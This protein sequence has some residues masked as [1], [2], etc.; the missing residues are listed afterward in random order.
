M[1][2]E[3]L[4]PVLDDQNAV[5]FTGKV[6]VLDGDNSALLGVVIF[7]EGQVLNAA[8]EGNW[9]L[10]GFFSLCVADF[11][12]SKRLKYIVEPEFVES[13]Q[14]IPYPYSVLKRKAAEVVA[15]YKESS[16]LRPPENLK[17]LL[18][19]EFIAKGEQVSGEEFSLMTSMVDYNKVKEIYKNS[20]LLDYQITNALVSLRKKKAITVV[21]KG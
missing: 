12:G 15:M 4:F 8:Y 20:E 19:P 9:G 13:I 1:S 14:K 2:E 21:K 10:K 5:S 18:N 17:L 7:H 3:A 11:D 16:H 6:N